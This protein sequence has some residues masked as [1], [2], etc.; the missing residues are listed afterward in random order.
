[1]ETAKFKTNFEPRTEDIN[2]EDCCFELRVGV[3]LLLPSDYSNIIY[4]MPKLSKFK[5][6]LV[7][8]QN[9]GKTSIISR[10]IHDSFEFTSNVVIPTSSLLSAS[11]SSPKPCRWRAKP[12]DYSSGIQPVNR[13]FEPSYLRTFETQIPVS[14]SSMSVLDLPSKE[15][16]N[17][18]ISC[19]SPVD[20]MLSSF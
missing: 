9:V 14:S 6:V 4:H 10:F 13:D 7:G 20:K 15:L 16:T 2:I 18:L 8:D 11:T 19:E 17:G 1:M 3:E 12:Y 5:V